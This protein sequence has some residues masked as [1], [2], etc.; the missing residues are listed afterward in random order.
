M[1]LRD[2]TEL[3]SAAE[4]RRMMGQPRSKSKYR[5]VRTRGFHSKREADRY[6][7]LE[8]LQKA[9]QIRNL[10]CQV[11]YPLDIA[12][13]HIC[14]YFADFVYQEGRETVVEDAKG[15]HTPLFRIKAKLMKAIYSVEVR[16][17]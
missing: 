13:I 14:N 15:F 5:N 9:G 7:E 16:C 6:D 3:I 4:W 1:P 8:L 12:G 10:R 2:T 11:K 17:T